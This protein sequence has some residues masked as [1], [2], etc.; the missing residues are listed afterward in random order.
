M[1]K[2][3]LKAAVEDLVPVEFQL[4]NSDR[5]K[6]TIEEAMFMK[7]SVPLETVGVRNTRVLPTECR[8]RAATYKGDFKVRM[9]LQHNEKVVSV[10]RSV[11]SIP[12]MVRVS[13][14][15]IIFI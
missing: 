3:G 7:P 2:D 1:L 13:S 6:I 12:I 10:D 4:N 9:T 8:Q 14:D 15:L 5:I 11:G